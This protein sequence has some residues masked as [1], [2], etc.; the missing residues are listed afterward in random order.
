MIET[1]SVPGLRSA[2][3]TH[4]GRARQKNEDAIGVVPILRDSGLLL[5]VCDGMGG[6]SCG[7][8]ASRIVRDRLMEDAPLLWPDS[9]MNERLDVLKRALRN[10]DLRV[11]KAATA[12]S[13]LSGMGTTAV[14]AMVT[15]RSA[16][17][18][19][20]G[21]SRLY[22]FRGGE[23]L[24]RTQDDTVAEMMRQMGQ[25]KESE[26]QHHPGRSKL[27]HSLGSQQQKVHDDFIPE[28]M[29]DMSMQR[30]TLT[31]IRGDTLLLC[32]DGLHASIGE[33]ALQD[34]FFRSL[35][36]PPKEIVYELLEAALKAGGDDNV[37]LAVVKVTG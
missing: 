33:V 19:H 6:H 28:W 4:K 14:V 32:T 23:R 9:S 30:A 7:E 29:K 12:S 18:L 35:T 1:L 13:R 31:L 2:W 37:T 24:Y 36:H 22:H 8:V 27:I 26:M 10:A 25:I 15:P 5:V 34:I 16:L 20:V 21:D 11:R 3:V 17:H